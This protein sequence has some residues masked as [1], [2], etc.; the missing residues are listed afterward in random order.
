MKKLLM[1]HEEKMRSDTAGEKKKKKR[2]PH[3]FKQLSV[4]PYTNHRSCLN[5][6]S[7]V[8]MSYSGVHLGRL[9][10]EPLSARTHN[11]VHL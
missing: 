2:V 8:C 6:L 5:M 4:E 10:L 1:Q 3:S 7:S 9:K 11:T